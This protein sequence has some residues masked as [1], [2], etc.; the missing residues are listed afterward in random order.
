[1]AEAVL[2]EGGKPVLLFH[3]VLE[4]QAEHMAGQSAVP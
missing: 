4:T 1:V 2:R 3:P